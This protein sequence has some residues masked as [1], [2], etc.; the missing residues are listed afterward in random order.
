MN[1]RTSYRDASAPVCER[2]EDLLV[3]MTLQEKVN[4]LVQP[5]N[6][7]LETMLEKFGQEGLGFCYDF[8]AGDLGKLQQQMVERSRLGIPVLF[9]TEA[10]HGGAAGGTIFP[11]PVNQAATW[12]P[13]L[14]KR[15]HRAIAAE[16]TA[17]NARLTFSPN[18]DVHV[19]PRFG[20]MEE[21]WGEDPH[22]AGAMARA[23]VE[24]L[25]GESGLASPT[26]LGAVAKHFVGYGAV[27]GGLDGSP[28]LV[29]EQV[30]REVFLPPFREAV[31]AGVC[32]IM[33]MHSAFMGIPAHAN[34]WLLHDVLRGELGFDGVVISDAN[35]ILALGA[36][37]L[38]ETVAECAVLALRAGVDVDLGA[39]SY[40]ALVPAVAQGLVEEA[41]IDVAVRRVL[42][43]KFEL[44]L[45]E[46]PLRAGASAPVFDSAPSRQLARESAARSV[47]LLSNPR[48][49]LPLAPPA[50]RRVTLLGPLAD[51]AG[52]HTG[53]YVREGAPV[54]TVRQALAERLGDGL[55]YVAGCEVMTLGCEKAAVLAACAD[56]GVIVAVVGDSRLT[57][58]ESCAGFMTG[59]STSLELPGG[60]RE[61]LDLALGSGH[62]VVVVLLGGRPL[63]LDWLL[64]QAAAVLM[65]WR[66]GEEGGHAV[67]D[68]LFG[69]INPSART[70]VSFPRSAGHLPCLYHREQ[71]PLADP[72]YNFSDATAVI[73]FGFGL[74]Y[75]SFTYHDARAWPE[76][77]PMDSVVEISVDVANESSLAGDEVA[78]VYLTDLIASRVRPVKQLKAF[79]RV[80]LAAGE[81]RRV[82][83]PIRVDALS[84]WRSGE[85]V[86][87]SGTF[88]ASIGPHSD[89][90]LQVQFTAG[91]D[92]HQCAEARLAYR[93]DYEDA[94][95]VPKP[96]GA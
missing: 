38:A 70:P 55:T 7:T 58:G 11:M 9:V 64:P 78:Q 43:L 10:L 96:E 56:A 12:D 89:Q 87:E 2:V 17:V 51:D 52:A 84:F 90:G 37:G 41:E 25:Q 94:R 91:L 45:F 21:G 31:A 92:R 34:R 54:V 49:V 77:V 73:P 67:C 6:L 93:K 24:G 33:P 85:Y 86:V 60:Q 28:C 19:D 36:L 26:A 16:A 15:I 57:C 83:V 27:A 5:W 69:E 88:L 68:V 79:V 48:G 74:S 50:I 65:A 42:R 81:R 82:V 80:H 75:S 30:L 35:D 32:G 72:R 20:R 59:D 63:C 13:A 53:G 66:P 71:T 3:R 76:F 61:L 22:L 46:N 95:S 39:R 4:Q 47:V 44:G 40:P 23:A 29:S 14:V 18:L 1:S 62:P 8:W